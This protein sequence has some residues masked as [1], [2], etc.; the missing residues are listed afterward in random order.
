M[1]SNANNGRKTVS[2]AKR[3]EHTTRILAKT[4]IFLL[5]FSVAGL[6]I[7]AV[8]DQYLTKSDPAHYL[9]IANKMNVVHS[10]VILDRGLL[11]QVAKV[12]H[13]P[14][15][16]HPSRWEE[17]E[18]PLLERIGMTVFLQRRSPPSLAA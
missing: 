3:K 18:I 2:Q 1:S 15:R 12:L 16:F 7:L 6:S 13:T 4:L 9:K 14:P 11:G 10:P 17:P 5:I 8:K